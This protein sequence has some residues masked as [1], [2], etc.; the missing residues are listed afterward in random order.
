MAGHSPAFLDLCVVGRLAVQV[1]PL[2]LTL[3]HGRARLTPRLRSGRDLTP[4][5]RLL[6]LAEIY[7][8]DRRRLRL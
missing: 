6:D 5:S 1:G 8:A 3:L 2:V 4:Q 7:L